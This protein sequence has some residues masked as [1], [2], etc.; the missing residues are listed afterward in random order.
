VISPRAL[1]VVAIL[2]GGTAV[3]GQQRPVFR[4]AAD[5]VTIDVAVRSRNTPVAGLTAEDFDVT[6]NGVRQQVEML[7]ATSLPIDLT[8][9]LDVSGSMMTLVGPMTR[10]A[11]SVLDMLQADDRLR[12]IKVGTYVSRPV[13][14]SRSTEQL[15][16]EDIN[17][18]EMT[19]LYDGL[20]ASMMRSRQPDRR[21]VIVALTDGFDTTS[22]LELSTVEDIAR[23]TDSVLYV[24]R[25]EDPGTGAF[26]D[27][28]L[29]A[30][31]R[32]RWMMPRVRIGVGGAPD[33]LG[34]APLAALTGG[35]FDRV[36]ATP[37]GLPS[38]VK[39]VLDTFRHSYVL[40]YHA[41]GVTRTG[42][43]EVAV[44]LPKHD[45]VEIR[46]RKGYFGG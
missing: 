26:P 30:N 24:V 32:N 44:R 35:R 11:N 14:F 15:T 40:R 6:D 2:A 29:R 9:V 28:P 33:D 27:L 17:H 16:V 12:I 4:T 34:L 45:G 20:A 23:R 7:D 10:Y 42:W 18:G 1:L 46:A 41:T 8:V 37:G 25:P 36:Y 13:D 19:S 39:V 3:A 43:H 22:T 5:L 38:A 21:H 31:T